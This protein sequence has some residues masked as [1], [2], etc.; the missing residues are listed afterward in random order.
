VWPVAFRQLVLTS[1]E[2]IGLWTAVKEVTAVVVLA[3]TSFGASQKNLEGVLTKCLIVRPTIRTFPTTV[4]PIQTMDQ[5]LIRNLSK[6][7]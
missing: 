3:G 7:S 5:Q 1:D 4:H 2:T 6:P